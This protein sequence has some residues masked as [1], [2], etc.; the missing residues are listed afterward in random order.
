[1]TTVYKPLHT[2]HNNS[3]P[4]SADIHSLYWWECLAGRRGSWPWGKVLYGHT[5]LETPDPVRSPKLSNH[6]RVQYSGGG[7]PGKRTYCTALKQPFF[8]TILV[9]V[10]R[11]ARTRRGQ[12]LGTWH[13]DLVSCVLF[14]LGTSC[15]SMSVPNSYPGRRRVWPGAGARGPG[16]MSRITSGSRLAR[17]RLIWPRPPVPRRAG[18]VQVSSSLTVIH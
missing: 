4:I 7:P 17:L 5:W 11:R 8:E 2:H 1:M 9:L 13:L 18:Q 10:P 16:G 14:S 6:R 3:V 15:L 12:T